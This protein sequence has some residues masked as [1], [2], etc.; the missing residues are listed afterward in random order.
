MRLQSSHSFYGCAAHDDLLRGW[1]AVQHEAGPLELDMRAVSFFDPYGIVALVVFL[2]SLP[3]AAL[4]VALSMDEFPLPKG[5]QPGAEG[6]VAYLTEMGFWEEVGPRLAVAPAALP[7]RPQFSD[8]HNVLIDV[9]VMHTRDAVSVMLRKS[10]ELLQNL[11]FGPVAKMH[12]LTVL[13][14]ISGNVLDHA[15][16]EL[17]GVVTSQIY[18]S[19][20]SD[21]R[22]LVMSIGD[23]GMGVKASL[24]SNQKLS[25]RL[26]SDATA[27]GI[28]VASGNSRFGSGGRGGG[29]PSVLD[30]AKRYGGNITMRSGRGALAYRG[31]DD[32]KRV[33]DAPFQIGTQVR[34]MLPENRLREK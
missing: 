33:F 2:Q 29:L 12:V 22:Y 34:I 27:L 28:A 16:S 19:R 24:A 15:G 1:E 14:E 7:V 11:G 26:D 30:I 13:S 20:R 18:R 32:L 5:Q 9:T 21:V 3:G 6:V 31:D 8:D 10:G 25:T 23:A 17:G 4:P